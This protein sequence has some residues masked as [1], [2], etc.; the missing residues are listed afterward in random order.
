MRSRQIVSPLTI[1]MRAINKQNTHLAA[2][3]TA[4][5][6]AEML[7]EHTFSSEIEPHFI[8]QRQP[9]SCVTDEIDEEYAMS[10]IFEPDIVLEPLRKQGTRRKKPTR[11]AVSA[12]KTQALR[13][14]DLGH[15]CLPVNATQRLKSGFLIL[16]SEIRLLIY[17]YLTPDDTTIIPADFPRY[18]IIVS[19][20][21]VNYIGSLRH[22][23]RKMKD[24]VDCISTDQMRT[25]TLGY[26][27][28][29]SR[30]SY[31]MYPD[32]RILSIPFTGYIMSLHLDLDIRYEHST[33]ATR[34]KAALAL[35]RILPKFAQLEYMQLRMALNTWWGLPIDQMPQH[36][37]TASEPLNVVDVVWFKRLA[38]ATS[39]PLVVM[40]VSPAIEERIGFMRTGERKRFDDG[41]RPAH[42]GRLTADFE[43]EVD[44]DG[45]I[46]NLMKA[47]ANRELLRHFDEYENVLRKRCVNGI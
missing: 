40:A 7:E 43:L 18:N 25:P 29:L 31:R 39:L 8:S 46:E 28:K 41:Q 14:S 16:P 13:T 26:E 11:T 21:S 4:S 20:T 36:L 5:T 10:S 6:C 17:S 9:D 42:H 15:A 27:V 22:I 32:Q 24:E 38:L 44:Y 12:G 45:Q 23:R 3:S 30:A 34:N 1:N 19:A 37:Q 47:S 33:T 2:R 35:C